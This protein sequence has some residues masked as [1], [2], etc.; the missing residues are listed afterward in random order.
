MKKVLNIVSAALLLAGCGSSVKVEYYTYGEEAERSERYAV[1]VNGGEVFVLKTEEPHIAVFGCDGEVTVVVE[2]LAGEISSAAVRPLSKGYDPKIEGNKVTFTLKTE[3]HVSVELDGDEEHPLFVFAS[4][5]EAGNPDAENATYRFS[6]GQ[7]YDVENIELAS[8]ETL[9]V[10]GGAVVR[11]KL[12]AKDAENIAVC[13]NGVVDARGVGYARA[14]QFE[15][16]C[17]VRFE[18]ITLLNKEWWSTVIILCDNVDMTNYKSISVSSSIPFGIENDAID[19]LGCQHAYLKN[20]FCYAHDD[21]YC[22]KARKW[23][24]GREV[25]DIRFEGCISWNVNAGNGFELGYESTE[26]V[27][28]VHYLNCYAIHSGT[29]GVFRRGAF[30]IHNGSNADTK[31]VT[32]EN[33]YIEDP[34]EYAIH[35][36]VVESTYNIGNGVKWSGARIDGVSFKNVYIL[37][38]APEG[39]VIMGAD[40]T[41]C[42]EN[43]S[44]ENIV[45]GGRR[46]SS[47]EEAD[48]RTV[49]F[50]KN[51]TVK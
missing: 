50:A 18:N 8:G 17:N 23:D 46:V 40:D 21:N 27:S 11:G 10:E 3:D 38:P 41:Y 24:W 25:F 45:V 30:S 51:I 9:Y 19:L 26:P 2:N 20:C 37:H 28:D 1:T 15:S 44:F 14:V 31:N 12:R 34:K 35:I 36:A 42:V 32:Y 49:E 6:A 47:L 13:G 43:V 4:P 5:L 29:R 16:C 48:F 22:I 39:S 33:I 7:V